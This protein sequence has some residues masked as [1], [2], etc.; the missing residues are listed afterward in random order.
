MP[1][2]SGSR[3]RR[4][5]VQTQHAFNK[6][7][8]LLRIIIKINNRM[9]Y[10]VQAVRRVAKEDTGI[11]DYNVGETIRGIQFVFK[12]HN[13]ENGALE[14]AYKLLGTLLDKETRMK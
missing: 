11:S 12:N 10:N 6:E 5:R 1:V 9:I 4:I 7:E 13:R 2:P 8:H 14:L 3:L